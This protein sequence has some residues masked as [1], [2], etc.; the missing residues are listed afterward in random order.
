[1][2]LDIYAYRCKKCDELH[3]PFRMRCKKC[4]EL[5]PFEFE[6][7]P[8]P[9]KGKLLTFT[10]VYNLGGDFDVAALD[11]GIVELEN[12]LRMMGQLDMDKP[13]IGMSVAGRVDVVRSDAYRKYHGMIFSEA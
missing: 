3:Y 12:G 7:E 11:L 10:R 1:M 8:L 13:K 4:G 6:P 5:T 2:A 9:K